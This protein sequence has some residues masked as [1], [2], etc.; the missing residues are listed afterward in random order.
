MLNKT[1]RLDLNDIIK[2]RKINMFGLN[3]TKYMRQ[4]RKKLRKGYNTA[5]LVKLQRKE[6]RQQLLYAQ[7]TE[8]VSDDE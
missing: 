6:M 1:E 2:E 4:K 8:N 5:G 3:E 7:Q